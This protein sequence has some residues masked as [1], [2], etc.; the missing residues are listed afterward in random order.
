MFSGEEARR[1]CARV[2]APEGSG[3]LAKESFKQ[4]EMIPE[5][6]PNCRKEAKAR[7]T[8]DIQVS[9]MD[10]FSSLLLLIFLPLMSVLSNI[11]KAI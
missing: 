9:T 11:I 8:D 10:Y 4:K 2:P 1:V 5:G 7:Q 6:N 3:G